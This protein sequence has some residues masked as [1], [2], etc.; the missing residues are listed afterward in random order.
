M[1]HQP[2][3][4]DKNPASREER[5]QHWYLGSLAPHLRPVLAIS[6]LASVL[7]MLVHILLFP[8]EIWIGSVLFVGGFITVPLLLALAGTQVHMPRNYVTTFSTLICLSALIG[9]NGVL[10]WSYSRGYDM[11]Y[12]GVLAITVCIGMFSTL[13][14]RRVLPITLAGSLMF[15]GVKILYSMDP[16]LI[17][18]VQVFFVLFFSAISCLIAHLVQQFFRSEYRRQ[19]ALKQLSETDPLT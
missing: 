19:T 15:V 9:V 10:A 3:S 8:T 7:A 1:T 12:E 18:L 14:L 17:I 16:A 6:L 4:P 2:V 11:P 13:P 5:F